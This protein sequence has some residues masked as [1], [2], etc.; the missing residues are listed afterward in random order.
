VEYYFFPGRVFA[1][2]WMCEI[3]L[4]LLIIVGVCQCRSLS[5]IQLYCANM[6]EWIAVLLG[7][8]TLGE[9]GPKE[10]CIELGVLNLHG[11]DAPFVKVLW[12]LFSN[13]F[14]RIISTFVMRHFSPF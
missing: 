11:F 13:W 6:A 4:L 7:M 2:H 12:P 9:L 5:D 10:H 8:E 14:R 3:R 1:L